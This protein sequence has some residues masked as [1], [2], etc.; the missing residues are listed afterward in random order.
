MCS[1]FSKHK[2]SPTIS[3]YVN[4]LA[5]ILRYYARFNSIAAKPEYRKIFSNI[6]S[7]IHSKA[8][9]GLQGNGKKLRPL[10]ANNIFNYVLPIGVIIMWLYYMLEYSS[11]FQNM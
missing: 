8:S 3:K 4:E 6:D 2:N 9:K 5:K 1:V 10:N 7:D 11:C